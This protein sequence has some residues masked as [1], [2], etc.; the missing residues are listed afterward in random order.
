MGSFES[1]VPGREMPNFK[2]ELHGINRKSDEPYYE[3]LNFGHIFPEE[4]C[5]AEKLFDEH[6]GE[7][8]DYFVK[9]YEYFGVELPN[10]PQITFDM[11]V[12]VEGNKVK[13][14][15]NLMITRILQDNFYRIIKNNGITRNKML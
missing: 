14:Q 6:G 4:N 1:E 9:R 7:A 5:D 8:A 3:V 15:Y 10:N 2:V 11:L 13:S 12:Y